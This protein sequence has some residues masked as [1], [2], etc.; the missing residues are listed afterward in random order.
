MANNDCQNRQLITGL[1]DDLKMNPITDAIPKV[2][3]PSIAPVYVS[4][5]YY[6]T[7]GGSAGNST[8]AG[9]ATA[10]TA[11]ASQDTYLT[12]VTLSLVK[13]ATCDAATGS[14]SANI[15][16]NGSSVSVVSISHLTLNALDQT[17][18]LSLPYPIK[19]DRSTTVRATNPTFT[20]GACRTVI[21]CT[22]MV[23]D[24]GQNIGL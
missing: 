19:M 16:V 3:V 11:S 15:T 5:L 20:A 21:S 17:V 6:S 1:I 23:K 9:A 4:N 8:S 22:V 14:V 7:S 18:V 24:S 2:V 10:F 12:S 13:D